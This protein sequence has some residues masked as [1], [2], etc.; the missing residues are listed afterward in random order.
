MI[1]T[2]FINIVW[3]VVWAFTS[4]LR[5]L[6]DVEVVPDFINAIATA[7]TYIS[8]FDTFLPVK[9]LLIVLGVFI[10]YELGY[11]VYKGIMWIIKK[12]PTLN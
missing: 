2:A 12:I 3:A 1:I 9:T 8:V 4:P 5:L 10:S 11:F 7:S 6:N